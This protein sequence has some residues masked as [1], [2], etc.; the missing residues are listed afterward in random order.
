MYADALAD[1]IDL[2]DI[3]RPQAHHEEE[4]RLGWPSD[5]DPRFAFDGR[6]FDIE[7]SAPPHDD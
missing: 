1:R 6:L 5:V 3:L 4:I 2:T 7:P